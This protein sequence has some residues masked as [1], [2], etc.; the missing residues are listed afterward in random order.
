[1]PILFIAKQK[2]KYEGRHQK[3]GGKMR[4]RIR[5]WTKQNWS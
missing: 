2:N 1:V 3:Q 4:L 5:W